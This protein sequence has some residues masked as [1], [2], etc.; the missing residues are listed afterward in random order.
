MSQAFCE[1]GLTR[2]FQGAAAAQAVPRFETSVVS[3]DTGSR[4]RARRPTMLAVSLALHA[5]GIGSVVLVPLLATEEPLPD[6]QANL[7]AFFATPVEAAP[8]PPPPPPAPART[9]T[10]RP[11]V[12]PV[13]QPATFAAPIDVPDAIVPEDGLDLGIEGGLPG[14]VEGGVPGGVVGGV[15]GGLPSAP[16]PPPTAIRVGGQIKEPTKLKHVNPVYPELAAQAGVRGVVILECLLAPNGRVQEVK[17]VRGMP[18][19]EQAAVD[20]VRQWVYSPT[21]VEGVPVPV[22]LSVTVN[23]LINGR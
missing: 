23:F 1:P 10:R 6:P 19:L 16:P 8:P 4:E 21:L 12:N 15:V 13:P 2:A 17:V 7:R 5:L 9:A 20:A 18:L 22:I 14:G 3:A 11:E